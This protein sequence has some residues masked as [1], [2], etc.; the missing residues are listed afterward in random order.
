M[1]AHVCVCVCLCEREK[2]WYDY[3]LSET[4]YF[5]LAT[6]LTFFLFFSLSDFEFSL[7]LCD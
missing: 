5:S 6:Q 1:R 4:V 2:G 7:P 3:V